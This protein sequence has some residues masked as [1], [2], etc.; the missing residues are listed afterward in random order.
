MSFIVAIT[1]YSGAEYA[2]GMRKALRTRFVRSP[3][4]I[5]RLAALSLT[6]PIFYLTA[7]DRADDPTFWILALLAAEFAEGGLDNSLVQLGHARGPLPDLVRSAAQAACG[8]VLLWALWSGA[9]PRVATAA[10]MFA[11]GVTLGDLGARFLRH[12]RDFGAIGNVLRAH[13]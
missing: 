5:V 12:R 11:L 8:A 10:T 9:A 2:W 3:L 7:I 1:L 6:V 4:E 13:P